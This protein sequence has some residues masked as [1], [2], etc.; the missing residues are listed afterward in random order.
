[1]YI[2][3]KMVEIDKY[4]FHEIE[5]NCL[6][7]C[8]QWNLSINT[9]QSDCKIKITEASG[10]NYFLNKLSIHILN[11]ISDLGFFKFSSSF[12]DLYF[13][14]SIENNKDQIQY[15]KIN[16]K[17]PLSYKF[18]ESKDKKEIA[19]PN[20]F[21]FFI[22]FDLS[23]RKIFNN[24]TYDICKYTYEFIVIGKIHSLK[25]FEIPLIFEIKGRDIYLLIKKYILEN[26]NI[27]E[28]N[29]DNK[30]I[31]ISILNSINFHIGFLF[32]VENLGINNEYKISIL[33]V[34][35][36]FNIDTSYFTSNNIILECNEEI[37]SNFFGMDVLYVEEK[38][39][40]IPKGSFNIENYG[41]SKESIEENIKSLK[42]K[43]DFNSS[44]SFMSN[45]ENNSQTSFNN[46]NSNNFL[47]NQSFNEYN[48]LISNSKTSYYKK[49]SVNNNNLH[50]KHN[51]NFQIFTNIENKENNM[52]YQISDPNKIITSNN[53][54]L[55]SKN[56]V[57][58]FPSNSSDLNIT[59]SKSS[60]NVQ[61]HHNITSSPFNQSP[62]LLNKNQF[63]NINF[64][65][66]NQNSSILQISNF[67]QFI[68]NTTSVI[69]EN[70]FYSI[71][72]FFNSYEYSSLYGIECFY[73]YLFPSNINQ[74]NFNLTYYPTLSGFNIETKNNESISFF[75]ENNIFNRQCFYFKI[76]EVLKK[77]PQISYTYLDDIVYDKSWFAILWIPKSTNYGSSEV[78]F[79]VYYR[80]GTQNKITGI[81][82]ISI[83]GILANKIDED[84]QLFWFGNNSSNKVYDFKIQEEFLKTKGNYLFYLVSKYL[85]II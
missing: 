20:N 80:F 83:I 21:K 1:M 78:S 31:F 61:K 3:N 76:K 75:E 84:N 49:N 46:F 51:N 36:E 12:L 45:K 39:N 54:K 60:F 32:K 66:K 2:L 8:S 59:N 18:F 5:M 22:D 14:K 74:K 68:T 58:S 43:S 64:F 70:R 50:N 63:S 73:K 4:K 23:K 62:F 56:K 13:V 41:F 37:K 33:K 77:Y 55:Q 82:Y 16:P 48:D 42:N 38:G 26:K 17:F 53:L 9:L 47:K 79:L 85:Y 34:L 67:Y 25:L 24:I 11:Q 6:Q 72:D 15:L 71:F 40:K 57:E 81:R 19:N 52:S 10:K 29:E 69:D 27:F 7:N 35:I 65:N 30:N 44:P 28:N